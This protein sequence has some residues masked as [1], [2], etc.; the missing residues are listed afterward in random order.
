[1]S[2]SDSGESDGVVVDVGDEALKVLDHPYSASIDGRG[3][4]II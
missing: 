1:V 2:V 3:T 4:A